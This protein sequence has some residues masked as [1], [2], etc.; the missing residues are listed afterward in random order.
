MLNPDHVTVAREVMRS[1]TAVRPN[2]GVRECPRQLANVLVRRAVRSQV[3][4]ALANLAADQGYPE[5]A[6]PKNSG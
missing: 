1:T 5:P 4:C 2:T 6:A 3:E